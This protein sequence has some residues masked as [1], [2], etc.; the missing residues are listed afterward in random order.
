MSNHTNCLIKSCIYNDLYL[1]VM[2]MFCYLYYVLFV[3]TLFLV[4][5]VE[6]INEKMRLCNA[7]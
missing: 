6:L 5:L 2:F 4:F 3:K 1:T 7:S